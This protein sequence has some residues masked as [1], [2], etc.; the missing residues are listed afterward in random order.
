MASVLGASAS[1]TGGS[2]FN[3]SFHGEGENAEADKMRQVPSQRLKR[4]FSIEELQ[5]EDVLANE[6]E[7]HSRLV[8]WNTDLLA[9]LLLKVVA[10]REASR[11]RGDPLGD[12]KKTEFDM[13]RPDN[14]VLGEVVDVIEMPDYNFVS[15]RKKDPSMVMLSPVVQAQLRGYVETISF[16][17]RGNPFHNFEVSQ[18]KL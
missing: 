8:D 1:S 4:G 7:K 10:R 5:M 3:A 16:M 14:Q 2:S 17:Y 15:R 18:R 13:M 6:K 12:I 11:S 9:Q